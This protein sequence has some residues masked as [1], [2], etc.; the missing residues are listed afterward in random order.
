VPVRFR[1]G[2]FHWEAG[3]SVRARGRFRL[4]NSNVP[5][6]ETAITA[7]RTKTTELYAFAVYSFNVWSE[8]KLES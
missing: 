7:T 5:M 3:S 6:V 8:A 2:V 1:N 4:L